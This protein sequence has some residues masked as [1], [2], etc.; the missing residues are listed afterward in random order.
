MIKKVVTVKGDTMAEFV[1]R[2]LHNKHIGSVIVVD[3]EGR[4]EGIFTER[5]AI[6]MMAQ[7]TSLSTL[8]QDVMTKNPFTI[9]E[10]ASFGE[11]ISILASHG[12]RHLP[13]VDDDER[14]VGIL[15][16]RSFLDEIVGITR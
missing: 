6:Q 16:I 15:S 11:A 1:I 13:V 9:R 5:D 10:D 7:K 12:I 2:T 3:D 14:L 4:C 8:I